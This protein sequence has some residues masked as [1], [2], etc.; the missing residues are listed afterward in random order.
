MT[1]SLSWFFKIVH[2]L[3]VWYIFFHS[4]THTFE[5]ER[6]VGTSFPCENC[7]LVYSAA[8]DLKTHQ[9]SHGL[10]PEF[11]CEVCY[12]EFRDSEQLKNHMVYNHGNQFKHLCFN[13]G[14]AFKSYPSFNNHKRLF[15]RPDVQCP[16]CDICGK[17]FPYESNLQFHYK[18]HLEVREY[19]CQICGKSYKYKQSLKEHICS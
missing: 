10:G 17:I 11:S 5:A 7:K 16:I 15:H 14:R 13:C 3:K 9:K 1:W 12:T 8:E 2:F 19:S 4:G 18:R 6:Y